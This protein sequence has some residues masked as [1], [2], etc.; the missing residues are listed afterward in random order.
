M[1]QYLTREYLFK[2]IKEIGC[3]PSD[4]KGRKVVVEVDEIVQFRY[5][6][7][8]HFRTHDGLYLY[9]DQDI[10]LDNFVVFAKIYDQ[11]H[12]NDKNTTKEIIDARLYVEIK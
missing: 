3:L 8:A 10:F 11:V 1:K 4:K 12:W 7:N 6:H 9:L 2:C 5:Q